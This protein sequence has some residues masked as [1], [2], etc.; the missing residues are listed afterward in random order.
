MAV[1]RDLA[2]GKT[3]EHRRKFVGRELESLTLHSAPDLA[4][5]GRTA[6]LTENF[7]P[8]E[9]AQHLGANQLIRVQVS[10]IG[11]EGSLIAA[12]TQEMKPQYGAAAISV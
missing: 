2:L 3:F 11:P 4:V 5:R 9:L 8:V 7:L 12:R 10:A 1:L 6:A